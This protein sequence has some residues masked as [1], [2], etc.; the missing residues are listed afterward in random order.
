[1]SRKTEPSIYVPYFVETVLY[2]LLSQPIIANA[3]RA[4]Q[5]QAFKTKLLA[6]RLLTCPK[7]FVPFY[8]AWDDIETQDDVPPKTANHYTTY[9]KSRGDDHDAFNSGQLHDGGQV[10]DFAK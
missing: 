8:L 3:I 5:K 10:V 2:M 9:P 6:V 1:M 7:P 4:K